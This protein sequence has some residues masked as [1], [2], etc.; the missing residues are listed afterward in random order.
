MVSLVAIRDLP[1]RAIVAT[2]RHLRYPLIMADEIIQDGD[3]V[4]TVW[5]R[6]RCEIV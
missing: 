1:D 6:F 2:A 3:W 4:D 5:E